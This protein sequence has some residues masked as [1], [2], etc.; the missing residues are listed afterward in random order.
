M[1]IPSYFGRSCECSGNHTNPL[2][3]ES[4]CRYN[5]NPSFSV[6]CS[7]TCLLLRLAAPLLS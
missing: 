2:N 7:L 3:P 1:F 4:T 5:E 6:V